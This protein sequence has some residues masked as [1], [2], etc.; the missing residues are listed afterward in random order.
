MYLLFVVLMVLAA[1]LMCFVVLVQ[2]SKGEVFLP[3]LRLLIR[4]WVFVRQPI[5]LKS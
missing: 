4:L 5:S 3:H 2:N 1:I